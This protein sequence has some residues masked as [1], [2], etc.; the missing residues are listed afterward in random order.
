MDY[1]Y[2]MFG[3]CRFSRFGSIVRTNRHADERYTPVTVSGVSNKT[4]VGS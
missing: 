4:G 3:D 2:G 1:L